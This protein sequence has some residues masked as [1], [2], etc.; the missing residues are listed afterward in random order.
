MLTCNHFASLS[1]MPSQTLQFLS[2]RF[3]SI[4]LVSRYSDNDI[5]NV[6]HRAYSKKEE[7]IFPRKVI[8]CKHFFVI[9]SKLNRQ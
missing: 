6:N 1:N 5:A 4:L 9:S 7:K 2:F 3:L 8:T